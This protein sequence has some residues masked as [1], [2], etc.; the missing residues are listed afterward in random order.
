[1]GS[2]K[3]RKRPQACR[4]RW[5]PTEE[6]AKQSIPTVEA[7]TLSK[8]AAHRRK[9]ELHAYKCGQCEHWHIGHKI[10]HQLVKGGA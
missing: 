8:P 10:R 6:A 3:K 5:Y 1:M 2:K 9:G 4:K 7:L